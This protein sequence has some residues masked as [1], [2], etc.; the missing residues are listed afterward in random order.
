MLL[1]CK[2]NASSAISFFFARLIANAQSACPTALG[3]RNKHLIVRLQGLEPWTNRLRVYCSTNWAKGAYFCLSVFHRMIHSLNTNKIIKDSAEKS[4]LFFTVSLLLLKTAKTGLI[5]LL[6]F[7]IFSYISVCFDD[8]SNG[9]RTYF[10]FLSFFFKSF[11]SSCMD[12]WI[13]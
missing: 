10:R 4:N 9:S 11:S 5:I 6:N 7:T 8:G 12:F 2:H 13:L 3:L 1:M